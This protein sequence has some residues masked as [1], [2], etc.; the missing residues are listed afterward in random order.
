MIKYFKGSIIVTII[1]L[2]TAYFYSEHQL[3]DSGLKTLF[4]VF[5]LSVLEVSLSFD[6]AVVNAVKLEHMTP[7]WQH[8][9]ITWGILIAVFGM[10]LLFPIIIVS[11]FAQ[12]KILE[13]AKMALY[14]VDK[15]THYLHQ[16]HSSIL[17]F[18][19]VFLMM[20]FLHYMFNENKKIHWIKPLEDKL[21]NFGQIEGLETCIC[22]LMIYIMQHFQPITHRLPVIISSLCG[23]VLYLLVHG[24]SELMQKK[25]QGRFEGA[26]NTSFKAGLI[27]FIYLELLDASFS[28]DGVL[29]AFAISK[30]LIII[31]IGLAIGAMFVRSL[32]IMLVEKQTLKQYV[33]LEHGAHWAIGTLAL[34]MMIST[35]VVISEV[36]T[37]L[38]G[39]IFITLALISSIIY[40]K[41]Q[42]NKEAE[43]DKTKIISE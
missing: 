33:Y 4:I 22:V 42:E 11:T 41:Q 16:T 38:L 23:L 17:A 30:D 27:S 3:C 31:M 18:G 37:G 36:V 7:K 14:D 12:I 35:K 2:I 15:Y 5:I 10:R 32:T 13:T 21:S 19:G 28:L 6:N 25:T 34:I 43:K 8:R 39:L 24:L 1:G 26:I 9:F 40:N 29:G 20:L